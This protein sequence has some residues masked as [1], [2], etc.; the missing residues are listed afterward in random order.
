MWLEA[1]LR[2]RTRF[3]KLYL[4]RAYLGGG[5]YGIDAAAQYYFNKSARDVNLAEGAMLAKEPVQG[6]D[7]V[8]AARQSAG[9]ARG[10]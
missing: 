1:R 9:G 8:R 5:N 4:D 3:C 10:P 2:P 7:Q 6:S